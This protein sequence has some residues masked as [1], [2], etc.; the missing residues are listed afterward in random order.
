MDGILIG[1]VFL[2]IDFNDLPFID[3]EGDVVNEAGINL[4][5]VSSALWARSVC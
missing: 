2:D 1:C 5:H 3:C 4:K